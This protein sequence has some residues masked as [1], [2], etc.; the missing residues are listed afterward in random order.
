MS[1]VAQGADFNIRRAVI[2]GVIAVAFGV[3]LVVL[4]TQLSATGTLDVR[5][6]DDR[7]QD[8]D[9]AGLSREINERGPVLFAD[10]GTGERDI[11][12]QH[13]GFDQTKGWI[14]IAAQRPGQ[15]R[16]CSLIWDAD[17]ELFSDPCDASVT[18]PADGGE[19]VTYPVTVTDKSRLV[20]DL[21]AEEREAD[22]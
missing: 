9:A 15:P 21:N 3:G 1:P 2:T 4:V 7:F 8:I 18:V 20:I 16:E 17:R 13:L 22:E 19:Q 10:A 11:I 12:L 5:L 6:G 14:A